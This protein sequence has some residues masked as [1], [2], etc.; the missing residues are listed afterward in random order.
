MIHYSIPAGVVFENSAP[1]KTDAEWEKEAEKK[2]KNEK[3]ERE[4]DRRNGLCAKCGTY[5]HGDC[6]A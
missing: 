1:E 6:E 5:C 4:R 2:Y 3:E